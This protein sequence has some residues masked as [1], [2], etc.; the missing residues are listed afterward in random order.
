MKILVDLKGFTLSHPIYVID[1]DNIKK[2]VKSSMR[3]LPEVICELAKEYEPSKVT[4]SGSAKYIEG[5]KE[6][7][8]N[9]FV[10]KYSCKCP[11]EID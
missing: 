7:I 10:A 6:D 2:M 1:D 3:Y 11:F 8:E 5:I 4:L 9:T